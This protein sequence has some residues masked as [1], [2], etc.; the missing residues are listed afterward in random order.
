MV[1]MAVDEEARRIQSSACSDSEEKLPDAVPMAVE[2]VVLMEGQQISEEPGVEVAAVEQAARA[3][4]LL[5]SGPCTP[6]GI[7]NLHKKAITKRHQHTPRQRRAW[8]NPDQRKGTEDAPREL[9]G[10][11]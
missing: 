4:G 9:F 6:S 2:E 5:C 3:P 7:A 1:K 11:G 8:R 10:D